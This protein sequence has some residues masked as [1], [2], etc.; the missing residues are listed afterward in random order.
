MPVDMRIQLP[1]SLASY[2]QLL[3]D[4]IQLMVMKLHKNSHKDT[5]S[6]KDM[7][8][9]MDLLQLEIQEFEEQMRENK[10]D[11][12]SLVEL[13]DQANFSF[14]A[15]VALSNQGVKDEEKGSITA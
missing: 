3:H 15:Y 7:D 11:R 6:I 8:K 4:F 5:P 14:L 1:D 12:N 13:A 9:I 10:F 2:T